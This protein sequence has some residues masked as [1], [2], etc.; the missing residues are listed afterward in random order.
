MRTRLP[1]D[2]VYAT[3]VLSPTRL[4]ACF[5][6]GQ[7]RH[8]NKP[9]ILLDYEVAPLDHETWD[10]AAACLDHLVV[11]R[12][13]R[14]GGGGIW[15]EYPTLVSQAEHAK[16]RARLIPRWLTNQEAW[17]T[18]AQSAAVFL[19]RG[20][21]GYTA[22]AAAKM[23]KRPFLSE[24]GVSAGLRSDDP[25]T[26]AFLY[27]VVLGLDEALASEPEVEAA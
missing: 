8:Y 20:D 25:T 24:S 5:Y 23:E 12:R 14:Y 11:D 6:W 4:S 15:L 19:S 13:A 26:A 2:T 22:E 16:M 18:L 27:G 7:T 21:V 10:R 1:V 17:H 9:L 3:F